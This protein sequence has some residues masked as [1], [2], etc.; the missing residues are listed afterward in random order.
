MVPNGKDNLR[1]ATADLT[2]QF[3]TRTGNDRHEAIPDYTR[4]YPTIPN[5]EP[6][7]GLNKGHCRASMEWEEREKIKTTLCCNIIEMNEMTYRQM[8]TRVEQMEYIQTD[9]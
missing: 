9:G 2:R 3:R 6:E 8:K 7:N 5:Y 4:Q 1:L